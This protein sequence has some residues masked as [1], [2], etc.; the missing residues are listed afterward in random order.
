MKKRPTRADQGAG[1]STSFLPT[2]AR[3]QRLMPGRQLRFHHLL[4]TFMDPVRRRAAYPVLDFSSRLSKEWSTREKV[5]VEF[6]EQYGDGHYADRKQRLYELLD[7]L[8]AKT[9]VNLETIYQILRQAKADRWAT[10]YPGWATDHRRLVMQHAH[11]VKDLRARIRKV[12][13]SY[14]SLLASSGSYAIEAIDELHRLERLFGFTRALDDLTTLLKFDPLRTIELEGPSRRER[15][16]KPAAPWLKDVRT[17][18]RQAGVPDDPDDT[19]LIAVGL[20]PYRPA[21]DEP[22]KSSP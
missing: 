9:N 3:A 10:L 16:G 8:V 15:A 4:F 6:E 2:E 12:R 20:L 18:L 7:W 19:L 11:L 14:I 21:P 5:L 17:R 22:P 13:E 1:D